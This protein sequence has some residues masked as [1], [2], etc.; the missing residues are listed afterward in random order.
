MEFYELERVRTPIRKG[1]FYFSTHT[2]TVPAHRSRTNCHDDVSSERPLTAFQLNPICNTFYVQDV[3]F[4]PLK[5]RR[6]DRTSRFESR[7]FTSCY[8]ETG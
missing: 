1:Q 3:G 4:T 8:C 2:D 6:I 7:R 5:K